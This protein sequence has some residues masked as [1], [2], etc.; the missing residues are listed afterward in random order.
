MVE[1]IIAVFVLALAG[2]IGWR[3]WQA[4]HKQA[5]NVQPTTTVAVPQVNNVGDLDKVNALANQID[6]T[7]DVQDLSKLEQDLNSL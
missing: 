5:S 4:Q 6:P 3:V 7:S 1:A 2:F